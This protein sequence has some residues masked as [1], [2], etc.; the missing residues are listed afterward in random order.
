MKHVRGSAAV[1][2]ALCLFTQLA[3]AAE[4]TYESTSYGDPGTPGDGV[5]AHIT[6]TYYLTGVTP[7]LP[8]PG[9][10]DGATMT[11]FPEAPNTF[12][13]SGTSNDAISFGLSGQG[14]TMM[15]PVQIAG[16]T[17]IKGV[18]GGYAFLSRQ[19][20]ESLIQYCAPVTV[21]ELAVDSFVA[22]YSIPADPG[23]AVVTALDALA[24]GVGRDAFPS[25]N[26]P[27]INLQ[28]G[29]VESVDPVKAGKVMSYT[30]TV[31]N[32]GKQAASVVRA[33][34]NLPDAGRVVSFSASGWA[35]SSGSN[36]ISCT[37]AST[38]ASNAAQSFTVQYEAPLA[39]RS[40]RATLTAS[41]QGKDTDL[42]NNVAVAD[43]QVLTQC[44]TRQ[45]ARDAVVVY[46]GKRRVI[47]N[48]DPAACRAP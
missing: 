39:P 48:S 24:L 41:S 34:A 42:S 30:F 18:V 10:T 29:I 15:I 7:A 43:T 40:L 25:E 4:P 37:L 3:A 26:T 22:I 1:L 16:L 6:D 23:Y 9:V 47:A 33:T 5:I 44:S 38:L 36:R 8:M 32:I 45:T 11:V 21:D 27:G 13:L 12:T 2:A 28:S 17:T 46:R 20:V 31:R 35:C 14:C 19:A